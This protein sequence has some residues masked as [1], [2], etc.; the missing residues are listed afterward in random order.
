MQV[1]YDYHENLTP[2]KIDELIE[3]IRK[4]EQQ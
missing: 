3:G 1:N 4:K 2:E